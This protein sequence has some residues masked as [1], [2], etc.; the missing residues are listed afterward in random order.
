MFKSGLLPLGTVRL[1]R[2]PN[3]RIPKDELMKQ[4]RGSMME[5][6]ATIDGVKLSLVSWFDNKIV[7]LMSPYVGMNPVIN[8][9]RY[10][11]KDKQYKTIPARR[12]T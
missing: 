11:R 7:T 4:G 9:C 6:V 3:S 1:N 10:S 12:L 8:K 5:K 2:V